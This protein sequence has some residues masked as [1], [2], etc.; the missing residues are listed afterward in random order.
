MEKTFIKAIMQ[1]ED[2]VDLKVCENAKLIGVKR[3]LAG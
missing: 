1:R 2:F 3:Q